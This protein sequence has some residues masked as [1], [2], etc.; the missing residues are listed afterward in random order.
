M[1][2]DGIGAPALGGEERSDEAPS[3]GARASLGGPDP[4]V[5]RT[6][7]ETTKDPEDLIEAY[8]SQCEKLAESGDH[9]GVI[10]VL[11]EFGD[12]R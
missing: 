10:R 12:D 6:L 5:V 9:A 7:R 1:A 11:Q 4:E 2:L 8:V 3:A